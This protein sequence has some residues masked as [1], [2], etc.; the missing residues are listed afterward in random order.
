MA[1]KQASQ[2]VLHQP[3]FYRNAVRSCSGFSKLCIRVKGVDEYDDFCKRE[4]AAK[5][6]E[7]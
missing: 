2:S 1:K 7:P 4:E 3:P 5:S 6:S